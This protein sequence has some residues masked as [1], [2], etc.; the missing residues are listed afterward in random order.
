MIKSDTIR[1]IA[2]PFFS[3]VLAGCASLLP[4]AK[5]TADLPWENYQH[6]Q[7]IFTSIIPEKTTLADL[8]KIGI[9][10]KSTPN[11]AILSHADTSRKLLASATLDTT[12]LAPKV[13]TCIASPY[14]CYAYE[15][16]QRHIEREREGSFWL[17]FLNF[18]RKTRVFGWQ[19][20][21]LLVIQNDIVV[22]KLWSG[23]ANIEKQE[24]EHNPLGPLQNIGSTLSH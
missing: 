16:E 9:D 17:D 23:E 11:V 8:K 20:D 18:K 10:P 22:Y 4:D 13:K 24:L 2:L 6:A 1:C 14:D 7:R 5:Q 21:A 12:T 19:F 15:I 3:C